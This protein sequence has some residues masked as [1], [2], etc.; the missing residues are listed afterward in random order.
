MEKFK[1][2]RIQP[3]TREAQHRLIEA[4]A[5]DFRLREGIAVLKALIRTENVLSGLA[6]PCTALAL[7]AVGLANRFE[8]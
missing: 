3:C 1:L 4:Y 5:L 2:R 7:L 6:T 8:I